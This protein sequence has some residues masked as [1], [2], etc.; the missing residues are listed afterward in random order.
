MHYMPFHVL[1]HQQRTPV[2]DAILLLLAGTVVVLADSA[3]TV[4]LTTPDGK[5]L[6]GF[7]DE[8]LQ[9]LQAGQDASGRFVDVKGFLSQTT[10]GPRV[11]RGGPVG[12]LGGIRLD[13]IVA[14]GAE[15]QGRPVKG[16]LYLRSLREVQ[17]VVLRSKPL[18][19]R[20]F[21]VLRPGKPLEV[22]TAA[23]VG[24][25]IGAAAEGPAADAV[26]Q[27]LAVRSQA[28]RTVVSRASGAPRVAGLAGGAVTVP[29]FVHTVRGRAAG[30]LDHAVAHGLSRVRVMAPIGAG[31]Q[32]AVDATGL[33]TARSVVGVTPA[34]EGR[35]TV[36]VE[37]RVGIAGDRVAVTL[38]GVP[39]AAGEAAR[40][41]ARPGVGG[42]EVV[43]GPAGSRVDVTVEGR[44]QG[45]DV[46][47]R[48]D[49]PLDGGVRIDP[50]PVLA[51][52]AALDV[53]PIG[54]LFGIARDRM[55]LRAQ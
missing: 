6:D 3:E 49:V 47:A 16:G 28:L 54:E 2:W 18:T 11:R 46:G 31:E 41:N 9:V 7:G 36:R 34:S 8:A 32:T 4:S 10:P 25:I 15:V 12:G 29:D 51:G 55:R 43:A 52:A 21:P 40:V 50:R 38:D 24:A 5:D 35:A 48:F 53:A 23:E 42:V 26:A 30:T 17:D 1:S 14:A 22:L 44:V 20:P 19:A 37:Q 27:R 13:D 33:G 39:L 45:R